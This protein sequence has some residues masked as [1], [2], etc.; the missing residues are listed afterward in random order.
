MAENGTTFLKVLT[1]VSSGLAGAAVI[2]GISSYVRLTNNDV[3]ITGKLALI[4][5]RLSILQADSDRDDGQDLLIERQDTIDRKHWVY[6]SANRRLINEERHRE[7]VP[8]AEPPNLD[9]D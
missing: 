5:Q 8:P 2:G 6:L 4:D 7:G 9:V 1:G 3:A